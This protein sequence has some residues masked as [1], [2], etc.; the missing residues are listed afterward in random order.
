MISHRLIKLSKVFPISK[1]SRGVVGAGNGGG[2][3]E[4]WMNG[5]K[6]KVTLSFPNV[7]H[8]P[9]GYQGPDSGI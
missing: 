7:L 1:H 4:G 5:G 3:G 6:Q 8:F 9:T 2:G